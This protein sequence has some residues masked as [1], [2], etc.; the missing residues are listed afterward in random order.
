M[1]QTEETVIVARANA[2]DLLRLMIIDYKGV[3]LERAIAVSEG[4]PYLAMFVAFRRRAKLVLCENDGLEEVQKIREM[5]VERTFQILR[6]KNLEDPDY[7]YVTWP[8]RTDMWNILRD[9]KQKY[10]DYVQVVGSVM[11]QCELP[12]AILEIIL[13]ESYN[14]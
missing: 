9:A 11:K 4:L 3:S 10:A 13:W 7:H 6:K 8:T 5:L 14:G 12:N 1:A 2:V